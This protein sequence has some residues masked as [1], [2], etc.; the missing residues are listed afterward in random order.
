MSVNRHLSSEEISGWLSGERALLEAHVRDCAQCAEKLAQMEESLASFKGAVRNFSE[1]HRPAPVAMRRT[2][3]VFWARL[4]A[5]AAAVAI[6]AAI[7]VYVAHERHQAEI[8]RQDDILLQHV[9]ADVSRGVAA[10]M[11]PLDRLM[12]FTS[13]PQKKEQEK[14]Q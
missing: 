4:A 5:T 7:P 3:E 1:H 6:L 8:A 2:S 9:A 12:F 13:D 10:P 11:E 14:P